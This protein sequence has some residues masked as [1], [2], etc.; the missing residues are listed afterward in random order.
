MKQLYTIYIT[1]IEEYQTNT[2]LAKIL[3]ITLKNVTSLIFSEQLIMIQSVMIWY[4]RITTL[5][6]PLSFSIHACMLQCFLKIV[7]K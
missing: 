1:P 3:Y 2:N 5:N 4:I 6:K 7:S